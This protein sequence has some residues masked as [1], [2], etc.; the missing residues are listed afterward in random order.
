MFSVTIREKSGQVYTFHFDKPEIM[1]GRVKGNDVILPKQNISKRH[2]LV[3]VQGARFV[4][5]DLGS[6]NGTYVN[7]HRIATPVEVGS[8]DKVYLGDFVMQY[9]DLSQAGAEDAAEPA[10]EAEIGDDAFDVDLEAGLAPLEPLEDAAP[11]V[12]PDDEGFGDGL[13]DDLDSDFGAELAADFGAD[14]L[15]VAHEP[16]EAEKTEEPELDESTLAQLDKAAAAAQAEI[17]ARRA[18]A[19]DAEVVVGEAIASD[20][21]LAV[22]ALDDRM[23]GPIDGLT[24]GLE[25]ASAP[26]LSMDLDFDLSLPPIDEEP[27]AADAVAEPAEESVAAPGHYDTLDELYVTAVDTLASSLTGDAAQLSDTEWTEMEEK[28]I[29]F[30]DDRAAEGAFSAELDVDRLKRD[31]IYE[32]AGLGPLESLLDDPTVETIEVNAADS[33]WLHRDGA[34]VAADARFSGQPALSAAADRLVRA[35]GVSADAD[36][37]W[38]DGTLA[39][40]TTIRVA[41]PP[42]CPSGPVLLIRKP[43]GDAPSLEDLIGRGVIAEQAAIQLQELMLAG[44]SIALVGWTGAGR[45]TVLN[46]LAAE[47]PESERI[48]V[49]EQGM[50][51]HLSQPQVIRLDSSGG[52]KNVMRIAHKLRPDRVLLG[53]CGAD[54]MMALLHHASDGFAPWMGI[55]YGLGPDEAVER[56]INAHEVHYPGVGRDVACARAAAALDILAVFSGTDDSVILD[57]VVEVVRQDGELRTVTLASE[58]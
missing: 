51:L 12:V 49:T 15:D 2:A 43:R 4:V 19:S 8:E 27:L 16:L 46:A 33:I 7:G 40:G 1:I 23:T 3:Q 37:T 18:S 35:S 55:L 45:R 34:R 47:I 56:I 32:L 38:V 50:R 48:V 14:A 13:G 6:T 20:D 57:Q 21:P 17:A 31:L 9:Y 22:D 28:V 44:R 53:A 41:W 29:A 36:A 52:A 58:G 39:D 24:A 25:G 26:D 10:S 30:V 42:M 5:E 54:E 11:P